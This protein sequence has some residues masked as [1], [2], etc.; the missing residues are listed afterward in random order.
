M[1]LHAPPVEVNVDLGELE[2]EPPELYFLATT[3]N[4][5]CGGH[6]GDE[7]SMR[8]SI[9]SAIACA[10]T[11]A[12]HPSYPDREGFGRRA[13]FCDAAA[14]RDAVASQCRA[15]DDVARREGAR[16]ATL[17]AHGALNHDVCED[18]ALATALLDAAAQALPDLARVVGPPGV[19]FQRLVTDRGLA[20]LREGFADRRY[21]ER[22]RLLPRDKPDALIT[23]PHACA[24]Q[25]V[26]L[27]KMARVD[28]ICVHGDT[29]R[30]VAI[31]R[32]V[33]EALARDG[34]LLSRPKG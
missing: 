24:S 20:Y 3:V 14:V 1:S 16:V 22:M 4:V 9:A 8:R 6:A 27:A 2:V 19:P 5:A 15:L 13:R 31:A 33:R 25:G 23:D 26:M 28:T 7:A 29:P 17:K 21:D 30:A 18:E 34:L 10:T 32:A 12:A 11:I